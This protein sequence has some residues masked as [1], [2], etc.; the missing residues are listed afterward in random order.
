M[1]SDAYDPQDS[2]AA[3]SAA[4][5]AAAEDAAAAEEAA[6]QAAIVANTPYLQIQV[7]K[8]DMTWTNPIIGDDYVPVSYT[9]LTSICISFR[10]R[11]PAFAVRQDSGTVSPSAHFTSA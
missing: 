3:E 8:P 10:A 4:A 6:R 11:T 5:Q 2:S 1:S 9:H 7:L